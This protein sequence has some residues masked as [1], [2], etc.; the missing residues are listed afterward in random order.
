MKALLKH[1]L[2]LA[3][4]ST[5]DM[6]DSKRFFPMRHTFPKSTRNFLQG[7]ENIP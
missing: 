6:Q 5:S 1:Y 2:I 3:N 4:I 7:N